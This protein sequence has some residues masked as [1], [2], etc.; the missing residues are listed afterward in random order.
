MTVS[1]LMA[2]PQAVNVLD[3]EVLRAR[4]ASHEGTR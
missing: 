2:L 3:A 1:A 4:R